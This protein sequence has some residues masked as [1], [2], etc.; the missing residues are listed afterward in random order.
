MIRRRQTPDGLPFRL[1]ERK[2][3]NKTS[4]GYKGPDGK[5]VFKLS[6]PTVNKAAIAQIRREAI[7]RA[8]ELNGERLEIGSIAE[9]FKDYFEWQA[10][11]RMGD[12]RKK[13]AETIKEN[14]REAGRLLKSFGKMSP[15]SV[16]KQH[17]YQYLDYRAREGAPAKAN[18]EIAL[19][20]A[21]FEYGIRTGK[22][23][24]N[25]CRNIKYNPT[26]PNTKLV[27][28]ED[29][30]F[31]LNVGR[32]SGGQ[33]HVIALCLMT[34]YLCLY[35]PNEALKLRRQHRT[36]EG[37]ETPVSKRRAGSAQVAKLAKWTPRLRG[38]IDEALGLQ[39]TSS[40]FIF[41]NTSGQAYTRYGWATM[42]GRLM[43]KCEDQAQ[44]AGAAFERFTLSDMRPR[45]T[46]SK[47]E[48]GDTDV[49]DAT[50]H[51]DDRMVEK[52]YDRRRVREFTPAE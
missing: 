50:G 3:K 11:V 43:D 46:T 40:V 5:W 12:E 6:A 36:E 51:A 28:V 16:R 44:K 17:C 4:F 48:R 34:C 30:E 49:R 22:V 45:G 13:A 9:L 32:A 41:P 52:V 37:I 19:M 14:E 33:F 20:S 31:V 10:S 35:R 24:E 15:A 26:K 42:L 47:K 25:P 8:N 1:Y 23:A 27:K 38:I 21:V 7:Q 29:I 2:G 18:K 39:K